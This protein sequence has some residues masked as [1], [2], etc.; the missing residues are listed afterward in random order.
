MSDLDVRRLS[1]NPLSGIPHP[2]AIAVTS[3]R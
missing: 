2:R 1:Q 3:L